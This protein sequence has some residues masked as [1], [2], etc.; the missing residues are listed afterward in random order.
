MEN[1]I[2]TKEYVI[3]NGIQ[4]DELYNENESDRILNGPEEE[5]GSPFTGLT[6]ELN[7]N[8][9]LAYYCFYKNGLE[10]GDYVE[11]YDNG[12]LESR[13]YMK[14][15]SI[16]GKEKKWDIDGN[17]IFLGESAFGIK[18]SFKKWDSEGS[19][20]EEKNEPTEEELKYIERISEVKE[21]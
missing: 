3:K 11:F 16:N 18:L 2:L 5:G 4:F 21:H 9:S 8:G 20:I 12:N 19:L 6:Y 1:D 17:L 15:G 7:D 10:Y 14:Y 13:Q